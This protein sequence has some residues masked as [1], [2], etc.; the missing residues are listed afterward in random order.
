MWG[1]SQWQP[2]RALAAKKVELKLWCR[3][4]V[5]RGHSFSGSFQHFKRWRGCISYCGLAKTWVACI[6]YMLK[7]PFSI[8]KTDY[9]YLQFHWLAEKSAVLLARLEKY[10]NVKCFQM[11]LSGII[12]FCS[13]RDRSSD[14][15]HTTSTLLG[16]GLV[17]VSDITIFTGFQK[18]GHPVLVIM[19]SGHPV[20]V[21]MILDLWI[22]RQYF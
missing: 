8:L 10:E 17:L 7:V 9:L 3:L 16:L 6:L 15:F 18:Q 2:R 20:L 19:S 14:C 4:S 13:A 22:Y 12:C 1:A 5:A 21:I 11:V